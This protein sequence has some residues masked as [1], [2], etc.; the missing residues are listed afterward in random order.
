[1]LDGQITDV[2]LQAVA[3]ARSPRRSPSTACSSGRMWPAGQ[4]PD[5]RR[6]RRGAGGGGRQPQNVSSPRLISAW[7][8]SVIQS[9]GYTVILLPASTFGND[10][11]PLLAAGWAA[12]VLDADDARVAGR[13]GSGAAHRV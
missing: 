10:L 4:G 6:L 7:R 5:R 9:G 12:C 13:R 3:K 1:V 2:T 8:L 11:A